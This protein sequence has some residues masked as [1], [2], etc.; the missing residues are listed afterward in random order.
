M[1]EMCKEAAESTE[2][3]EGVRARETLARVALQWLKKYRQQTGKL[4]AK[5]LRIFHCCC[6]LDALRLHKVV[7]TATMTHAAK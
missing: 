4:Q 2:V 7:A 1:Q 6:T 5:C 3:G